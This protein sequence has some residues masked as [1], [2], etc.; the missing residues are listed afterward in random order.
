MK[1]AV[2]FLT[3]V[4]FFVGSCA[5]APAEK[6]W[7]SP[8]SMTYFHSG[9]EKLTRR[10][11]T[12]TDKPYDRVWEACE[13]SLIQLGFEFYTSDKDVGEMRVR[14]VMDDP[15]SADYTTESRAMTASISD[16]V[17]SVTRANDPIS[18]TISCAH[19]R[20]LP[21]SFTTREISELVLEKQKAE[22]DRIVKAIDKQLKK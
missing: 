12:I 19:Y 21:N 17:I 14:S 10:T 8:A 1:K 9:L 16:V 4:S 11:L 22:V 2:F 6:K 7:V 20:F 13:R 3:L 18:L 15:K 5:T